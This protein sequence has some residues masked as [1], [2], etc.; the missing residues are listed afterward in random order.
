MKR[1]VSFSI[2][3]L[4]LALLDLSAVWWAPEWRLATKPLIMISLIIHF[5]ANITSWD[6]IKK[7]FFVAMFF[8]WLGDVFLMFDGS[9][10]FILGLIS[11]LVMQLLYAFAFYKDSFRMDMLRAVIGVGLAAILIC[12][13]SVLYPTLDNML[14]PVTVYSACICVM[15]YLASTRLRSN[16]GYSWVFIGAFLFMISDGF[17]AWTRF[18]EPLMYGGLIIMSTYILAQFFICTGFFKTLGGYL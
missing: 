16:E 9:R 1:Y 11:F 3:F 4:V 13:L 12:Y 10:Y 8:A 15:T 7:V 17:I 2:L 5:S 18:M 6:V 14:I